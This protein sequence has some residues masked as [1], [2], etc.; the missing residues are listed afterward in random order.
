MSIAWSLP[1][2]WS[3]WFDN[4][5]IPDW[6]ADDPFYKEHWFAYSLLN[7]GPFPAWWRNFSHARSTRS[8]EALKTHP[9]SYVT[10]WDRCRIKGNIYIEPWRGR[11]LL[12]TWM[13]WA[14]CRGVL[15]GL[16]KS[17]MGASKVSGLVK[18]FIIMSFDN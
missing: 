16:K 11:I 4:R 7:L 2:L 10:C 12:N 14:E 1:L 5:S 3:T 6:M 13:N 17:E 15:W 8:I 9:H 18:R